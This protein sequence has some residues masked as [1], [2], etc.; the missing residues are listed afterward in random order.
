LVKTSILCTT[1]P[2]KIDEVAITL[3]RAGNRCRPGAFSRNHIKV[4]VRR[5]T[6]PMQAKAMPPS[7]TTPGSGTASL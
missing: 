7:I 1:A 5:R 2:L 4:V 3:R 6:V